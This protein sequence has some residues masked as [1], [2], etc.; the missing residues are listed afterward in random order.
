MDL[1]M[2]AVYWTTHDDLGAFSWGRIF[3]TFF[4]A[5]VFGGLLAFN[6]ATA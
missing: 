2:R 4:V 1:I 6:I 5:L 3:G